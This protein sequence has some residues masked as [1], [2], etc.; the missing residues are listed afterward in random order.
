MP[1]IGHHWSYALV[2]HRGLFKELHMIQA[3]TKEREAIEGWNKWHENASQ[4]N[5]VDDIDTENQDHRHDPEEP[6]RSCEELFDEE[7]WGSM[8]IGWLLARGVDPLRAFYFVNIQSE[9]DVIVN[10]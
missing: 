1:D 8:A 9:T 7:M 10:R 4:A 3:T 2:P 6:I 5:I